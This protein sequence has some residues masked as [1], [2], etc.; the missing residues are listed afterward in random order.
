MQIESFSLIQWSMIIVCAFLTGVSKTG[1]PGMGIL[2]VPL[3]ALSFPAKMS[4]GLL[5]PILAFADIA[6]VFYYRRHGNWKLVFRLLPW[7][8]AGIMT[9]SFLM[10][11]ISDAVL[12]P[13]IGFI[14]LVML[15]LNFWRS[16]SS[17]SFFDKLPH[18]WAFSASM[19]FFAGLTTQMANAAGPVM[20]I[21][22]LSMNLPKN[23]FIG[24]GAWYFLILNWLKIPLFMADGRISSN[25]LAYD[26]MLIPVILTG[27]VV[28]IL[29]LKKIPQKSFENV[30]QFL[31]A[32]A[33]IKLISS[34]FRHS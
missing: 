24:T 12:Q 33:A 27:A 30:V 11:Y 25:T 1:F 10:P 29:L 7:A 13:M 32:A 9:G 15:A 4:T 34:I 2:C 31:A 21:Y 17:N 20:A 6:A 22:L 23:E 18:H 28:G 16:K 5:L 14:V 19:G 3:M 8:L 26:F